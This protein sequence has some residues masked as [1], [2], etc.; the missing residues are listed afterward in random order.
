MTSL[1]KFFCLICK[2]FRFFFIRYDLP[3]QNQVRLDCFSHIKIPYLNF[4]QESR[5]NSIISF[6]RI[7]RTYRPKINIQPF[8]RKWERRQHNLMMYKKIIIFLLIHINLK[9]RKLLFLKIKTQYYNF[10]S[11]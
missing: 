8:H 1:F 5:Q 6:S 4:R 7:I 11:H 9:T 2:F 3:S 10:S